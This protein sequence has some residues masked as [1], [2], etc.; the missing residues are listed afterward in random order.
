MLA[1]LKGPIT[2]LAA[3]ITIRELLFP[4]WVYIAAT[5]LCVMAVGFALRGEFMLRLGASRR[6]DT[7]HEQRDVK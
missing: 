7:P 2:V 6:G 3:V 1:L 5:V 4:T